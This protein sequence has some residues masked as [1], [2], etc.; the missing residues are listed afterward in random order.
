MTLTEFF[1]ENQKAAIAFSGGVDSAYLLYAALQSGADVRAYYVKSAF[2]PQFELDDARRLAETLSADMRVLDVDILADETVAANP[3]DR[4]YHCK[5]RIFSAIASAAAAD[6]YT[7]LLDGTNASDDA[8]DRP[9]M[10]ALRELS[11]RSPLRECGLT[12]PEIRLLSREA[13][14]FTWDKPAYACLA[15]RVPAGERLTAEKLENTERAEDFLFSL[16]FTD[17]RVRLFSGAARLQLPAEQLPRL[18]E[19]RAKILSELKKTYS[20]VVLDLEVR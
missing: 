2:Q 11:V 4:C 5:R 7:L 10:R 12:K 19:R 9:G 18:L 17:F 1:H 13:G 6:G 3:P 14:L 15:T 8:G 16:G 20:A